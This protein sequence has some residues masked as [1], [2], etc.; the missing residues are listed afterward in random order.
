[1]DNEDS[2]FIT[3]GLNLGTYT[4]AWQLVSL[5]KYVPLKFPARLMDDP[6][7]PTIPLSNPHFPF[8]FV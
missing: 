2:H 5:V 3:V 1:L 6:K 8:Y 4:L 7:H